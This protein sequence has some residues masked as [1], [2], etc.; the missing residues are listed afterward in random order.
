MRNWVAKKIVKLRHYFFF[1]IIN[2][3]LQNRIVIVATGLSVPNIPDMVGVDL[4]VGYENISTNPGEYEG[5]SVLILGKQALTLCAFSNGREITLTVPELSILTEP[6]KGHFNV[7]EL[8][9]KRNNMN[10]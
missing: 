10:L 7:S 5:K 9:T 2:S 4:T 6:K 1:I 8:I 3:F